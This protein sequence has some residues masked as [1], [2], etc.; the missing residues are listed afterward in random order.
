MCGPQPTCIAQD[1]VVCLLEGPALT[2]VD[3]EGLVRDLWVGGMFFEEVERVYSIFLEAAVE[4]YRR[5]NECS[6]YPSVFG[7]SPAGVEVCEASCGGG[8][9]DRGRNLEMS[10]WGSPWGR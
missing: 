6:Q 1:Q 10:V 4:C 3:D 7:E 5:R 2:I 8:K 9:S